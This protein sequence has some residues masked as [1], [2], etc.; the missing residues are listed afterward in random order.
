M[1]SI[2]LLIESACV[3]PSFFGLIGEHIFLDLF[4][5]V[6]LSSSYLLVPQY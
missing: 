1:N 6:N 2:I 5:S 3:C 4:R